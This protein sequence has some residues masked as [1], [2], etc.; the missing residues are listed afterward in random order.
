MAKKQ[1]AE[2]DPSHQPVLISRRSVLKTGAVAAV[3]AGAAT[4]TTSKVAQAGEGDPDPTVKWGMLIDLRKCVGCESCSVACKTQ[5][6]V[7]LGVFRSSVKSL[8]PAGQ[9][10]PNATRDQLPWLCNHCDD[11]PCI[12]AC[13]VEEIPA[14]LTMPNDD[15][16]TYCKKATYKRPDGL[17]LVDE[18]RCIGCGKCIPLCPY[19][20]RYRHPTKATSDGGSNVTDKCDFCVNRI[21]NDAKPACVQTCP[22]NARII[23]N[24]LDPASNISA[25]IAAAEADVQRIYAEPSGESGTTPNV[26]YIVPDGTDVDTRFDDGTDTKSRA[27]S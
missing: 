14:S 27:S 6:K 10:F 20:A 3:A 16:I 4:A 12:D 15:V 21:S 2:V 17:V 11:A 13:P 19:G 8:E 7:A 1:T 25:A 24:L 18:D 5:N 22:H 26:Y 23:G 9:T